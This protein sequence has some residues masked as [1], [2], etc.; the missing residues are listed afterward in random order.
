[1]NQEP[2]TKRSKSKKIEL[3]IQ[4]LNS[5][6]TL[7]A[8]AARL[9]Q[10]TVR[11]DTQAE[12]VVQLIESDPALASRIIT[13]ATRASTGIKRQSASLSKAVV[14]LGFEA[15]RNAVL[16]IKVF[17]ALG[18]PDEGKGGQF[19]RA[20]FWKHSLA[21]ACAAKMLVRHID[22]R[23]DPEEVFVCG[24][25]HDMGKVALD[26]CLPK[27]FARVV[28]LTESA[29]GNIAE[30]EQRILG[31]DH[32]VVGKRLTEKWNLP[33]SIKE[34][35]WLHHHYVQ[36]L[37]EAVKHRSIVQ[38]VHLA[39]ILAREQHI[40]YSGN[41]YLTNS[42]QAVAGELGCSAEQ[43][44]QV[45]RRLREQISERGVLLGLDE[46]DPEELYH[47]ALCEA[48]RELGELNLHLQQQNRNLRER[49]VYFELL[50]EL[51]GSLTATQSLVDVC[52]LI[53]D[54]WQRKMAG[55][56]CAVYSKEADELIIEGAVKLKDEAQAT[57]FLVDRTDDPE[58]ISLETADNEEGAGFRVKPAGESHGWFFEQVSPG[59]EMASTL[60][61]P[62]RH[63]GETVGGVLWEQAEGARKYQ[64]QI[65]YLA[66]FAA[67]AALAICQAQKHQELLRL[68]EQLAQAN[69]L[70]HEA[71]R[72]L[73]RK[74]SMAAVGEMACGAAHE[75]NNPLAVVV[76]RSQLLASSEED[77]Q[78]RE[79]LETISHCG[80][81]ITKIVSEL[82]EFAKPSLPKPDSVRVEELIN[83]AADALRDQA[84]R[85]NVQ[86][87]VELPGTL[88]EIFVD[89][90]QIIMAVRELILNAIES[91]QGQGGTVRLTGDHSELEN[92]VM[93]EVIDQGCGMVEETVQKAF[94]PF[95]SL[96]QAGRSR[97][98][99][100]S[101]SSRY[102]GENGGRL[103]L[104]S[105][106]GTGTTARL[107]LP[108]C[109]MAEKHPVNLEAGF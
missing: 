97:G 85:E 55:G 109:Q 69:Q 4:Q 12:E 20:G 99:G 96:R 74:R 36:A 10:I 27:S 88:P 90:E 93:L 53:A 72:E 2:E 38:T 48:N 23:V 100:L 58:A 47:E 65:N 66:A 17:E 32:T 29:R 33:E 21:V 25:L 11:N 83:R 59:F 18:G 24:L 78:R 60:M 106:P 95:F 57:V 28:Q 105:K 42:T 16:S 52:R 5:L 50:S 101:R 34:T 40:G 3:I 64:G 71:Q 104:R 102:I 35:V 1:M 44:D 39:D 89:E 41:Y 45:A 22:R 14:L 56:N 8:V 91:Y 75:V 51:T 31:I 19:D 79:I 67:G 26:A 9:L 86:I 98:L 82:M 49:S 70:L 80:Q 15:V 30:L 6:P 63:G 68:S 73:V 77:S 84:A 54:L 103:S 13:M 37:P 61:I 108:V 46:M 43:V 62:L 92:E 107:V 7:P 87:E 81:E 94:D 76:G